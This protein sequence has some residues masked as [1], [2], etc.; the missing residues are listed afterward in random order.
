MPKIALIGPRPLVAP[1]AAAGIDV[2][3]DFNSISGSSDYPLVF[4]TEREAVEM[5]TEIAAAEATGINV[6]LLPDGRGSTGAVREEL[7]RLIR[8]ATGTAS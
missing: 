2:F 4:I 6:V 3:T 8:Q 7:D 1:L 5:K